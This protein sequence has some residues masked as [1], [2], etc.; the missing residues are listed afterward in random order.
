MDA[1]IVRQAGTSLGAL[2]TADRTAKVGAVDPIA[3]QV[4]IAETTIETPAIQRTGFAGRRDTCIRVDA[5][6]GADVAMLTG[7]IGHTRTAR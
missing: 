3:H 5:L 1:S 7:I 4:A 2:E 6:G